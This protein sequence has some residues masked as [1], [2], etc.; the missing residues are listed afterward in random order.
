[1]NAR[2]RFA[3][4]LLAGAA[5]GA[6][7]QPNVA[8]HTLT[9]QGFVASTAVARTTDDEARV[10]PTGMASLCNGSTFTELGH[11]HGDVAD[12]GYASVHCPHYNQRVDAGT[13]SEL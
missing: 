1:M 6:A 13:A 9:V 12:A 7:A 5:G 2:I 10:R 8:A 3:L 4:I 11:G